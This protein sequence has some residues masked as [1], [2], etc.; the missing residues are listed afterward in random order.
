MPDLEDLA[1]DFEHALGEMEEAAGLAE[2]R[3]SERRPP[4]LA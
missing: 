3:P 1:R 2:Y 4:V